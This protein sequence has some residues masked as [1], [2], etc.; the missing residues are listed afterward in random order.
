MID[1]YVVFRYFYSI[2]DPRFFRIP[3]S[4][5]NQEEDGDRKVQ[6]MKKTASPAEFVSWEGRKEGRK[7]LEVLYGHRK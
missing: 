1:Y 7:W 3:W 2:G 6:L 5:G 4:E